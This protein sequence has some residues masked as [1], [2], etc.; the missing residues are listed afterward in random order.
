MGRKN[1]QTV[2]A[3]DCN[4]MQMKLVG[5]STG[6]VQMQ[7]ISGVGILFIFSQNITGTALMGREIIFLKLILVYLA[8]QR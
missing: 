6:A 8:R 4:Q 7:H 5:H 1:W 2:S 3:R